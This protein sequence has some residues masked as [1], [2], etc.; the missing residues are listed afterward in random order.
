MSSPVGNEDATALYFQVST[1]NRENASRPSPQIKNG[2]AGCA[3][4]IEDSAL[5]RP[6]FSFIPLPIPVGAIPYP[7][8]CGGYGGTLHPVFYP[9]TTSLTPKSSAAVENSASQIPSTDHSVLHKDDINNHPSYLDLHRSEVTDLPSCHW[10]QAMD[11]SEPGDSREFHSHREQAYHSGSYSQD[12]LKTS[13]SNGSVETADGSGNAGTALESGNESGVQNWNR[14]VS[15]CDRSRREAALIK[16][17]LKRKDRC[18]EKKVI[19]DY[20]TLL[21]RL[22]LELRLIFVENKA[23]VLSE[24]LPL[25]WKIQN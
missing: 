15:D 8:L 22:M 23:D 1:T 16:F 6:A 14:N 9:E 25:V 13:R 2:G 12:V 10:R 3:S 5:F 18:F 17:R 11:I 21:C 4:T 20:L 24:H 7:G 19:S